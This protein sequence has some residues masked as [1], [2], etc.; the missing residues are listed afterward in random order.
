MALQGFFDVMPLPYADLVVS[1]VTAPP[2]AFSGETVTI[3]WSVE[4]QGIGLTSSSSWTDAI[5]LAD[6]PEGTGRFFVGG[7]QQLGFLAPGASYERE[8][9]VVLPEG[10]DGPA[11]FFVVVPGTDNVPSSSNPAGPAYEFVFNDEGNSAGSERMEVTLTPPPNLVVTAV[12]IPETGREGSAID[13]SWTVKNDGVGPANGSWTDRLVL[14]RAN[15]VGGDVTLGSYTFNGPLQAGTDYTRREQIILPAQVND[16]YDL[17]VITDHGETVF[18]HTNEGDNEST[19][20]TAQILVERLPRP[21]LQVF[22]IESGERYSA[23][24]TGALTYTVI[25]QGP[26]ATETPNWIDR[27]YLSLDEKVTSD[28]IRLAS[29]QN[30]AALGT[31]ERYRSGEVTFTIPKRFRGTVY[32]LVETDAGNAVGEWPNETNNVGVQEIFIDP[33]P[34]ADLV[35]DNVVTP[36]QA[37][38]GNSVTVTYTVTNR[39]AGA[40]DI[41]NWAEQIWLTTDKNRPHPNQGDVLLSTLTYSDGILDV[42]EGYDRTVTVTLPE[43]V[44]SGEYFITP[45]VDPYGTVLED[46]LAVNVNP[47]DPTELNSSNYRAGG[48]DVIGQPGKSIQIIGNPPDITSPDLA[49]KIDAV[50]PEAVA[51]VAGENAYEITYTLTN[52]GDR[53]AAGAFLTFTLTETPSRSFPGQET[54]NLGRFDQPAQLAPGESLTQTL[55]M[56]LAPGVDAGYLHGEVTLRGDSDASNDTDIALTSVTSPEPNLTIT[57]VLPPSD[58][59]S[60]EEITVGYTVENT[61]DA[62]IWDETQFWTDQV[63]ISPDATFIRQRATLLKSV[64]ISNADPLNPGDSYART[65]TGTLPQGVDGQ[66]YVHVFTNVSPRAA[67][68]AERRNSWPVTSGGGTS[69]LTGFNRQAF[70]DLAGN[71]LS[72]SFDITYAEPD[73]KVTNLVIPDDLAA[74]QDV[75]ISFTVTNV[76]TRATREDTWT[77]RV[78]LSLDSAL[79][80][81]DFLLRREEGVREVRAEAVRRGA[82]DIGESYTATVRVTLP[83]EVVGDFHILA[84][85]D[86]DLSDTS[87]YR[88]TVSDRLPGLLGSSLGDVLEFQG[89]GNNVTG[90]AVNIGPYVAPELAI[91]AMTVDERGTRGQTFDLS[92]TVTNS[93]GAVPFQQ[94]SWDDLVYFSRD[95]LLDLRAD[96]FLGR[97]RHSGGLGAGESYDVSE[98]FTIPTDMATE[99]YYVFVITDPNR[100]GGRGTVFELD[101]SNN[102]RASDVPLVIE[103]P[104]PTDLEVTSIT[105]PSDAAAGDPI[106]ISW[107]VTNQSD[108]VVAEGQWSDTAFLSQ[109]GTWDLSDPILGRATTSGP[110]APGE[111]RTLSIQTTMPAATPGGYRVIVRTDIFNQIHEDVGEANNTAASADTI[112]TRVDEL[113]IGTPTSINLVPGGEK[114]WRITVPPDETLRVRVLSSEPSASN[115]IFLRHDALPSPNAFDATYDGPLSSDL[116]AVVP[117]TEPGT[118][119]VSLRN[120]SGPGAGTDLTV[121]AELL[122]LVITDVKTDRGGAAAFVTTRISGAQFSEDATL[123]LVRPGIAEFAPVDW[124]VTGSDEIIA[125]FDLTGAPLGLYDVIV[126][127]PSGAQALAPYRF[128]VER[129]I[130]GDVTIG[131]GGS[132]TILA[133]DTET[134]SIAL[135]NQSNLD[136]PYTY[137]EVGVP[138]L[139]FNPYVYGLPFLDFFTNVRGTPDGATD[140]SVEGDIFW[141]GLESIVNTNGQLTT[142]GFAFDVPADGFTGFTFNLQTYP[143][144][145]ELHD[146]AFGAFRARMAGV[147]PELDGILEEGG[148][149]AIGE[150]YEAVVAKAAEVSPQLGAAMAAFPFQDLYEQNVARPGKCEIPFIPFRFHV[151]A[152]ATSMTRDE[153]I[154]HQTAEAL[155]LRDNILAADE[156]PAPLVAVVADPDLWVNLYLA[157]LE[158]AGVLRAEGEVPPIRQ[159]PQILSLMATLA[160][161]IL[162]GPAGQDIRSDGDILGFFEELRTLYGH[163]ETL[164]ADI[165]FYDPREA[166]DCGIVGEVPVPE[167]PVFE[168]YDLGLTHQTHFESVR[169]YSPWVPFGQRGE[170]LPVDFLN[171]A[172]NPVDGAGLQEL[173]F[174][175]YFANPANTTGALASIEGPQTLETEGWLPGQEAL[176]FT[177]NFQND[178]ESQTWANQIEVVTQLDDDL[179]P[180]SFRLGDIRI[181]DITIDVPDDRWFYQDEIDFSDTLGFVLRISAG[182]DLF[183]DPAAARWV[184]QAVDPLTGEKIQSSTRGLLPP[185][186]EGNRGAGFVSWTVEPKDTIET[187]NRITSLARVLFDTAPPEDTGELIQVVDAQA[188]ETR[189]DATPIEGTTSIQIDWDAK[190]DPGAS[191]VRHVTLYVA[192]NGGDFTIWQRRLPEAS[193][194]LVYDGV[195]GSTY[196]FLALATDIAGNREVPS[197]GSAVTS[198][199][200]AVNLG[201][202]A[203][204]DST[205]APNFGR[206]PDPIPEPSKNPLFTQALDAVPA[207]DPLSDLPEFES[208]L[209]PFTARAFATGFDASQTGI[210]PLAV[211]ELASGDVLVSGGA[212]RGEIHRFTDR[213]GVAASDTLLIALDEPIFNLAEAADGSLWATTGGGALLQLDPETGA[214]AESYGRGLTMGLAIDDEN[215]HIY[216]GSNTG[217]LRFDRET[218]RFT[219]WSRDENLRVSSLAFDRFGSL[220]AVTWPDRAQV[221]EFS[222]RQRGEI[223]LEFDAPIDSIAFGREGTLLE[224]LLF[225]SANAGAIGADGVATTGG[226]LTMV[227]VTTLQ[228]VDIAREGTRGDVVTTTRDGRI[229]V[230]QSSQVDVVAPAFSPAV[231]STSPEAD[232]VVPLPLNV[233][234]VTFDTDMFAGDPTS[235]ASVLNLANYVLTGDVAGAITPSAVI[236]DAESRTA[237]LRVDNLSADGYELRVLGSVASLQGLRMGEDYTTRFT[238]LDDLSTSVRA[239]FG[240]TRYDRATGTV[241]YDVTLTNISDRDLVLPVLLLLDPDRGYDGT[242][243]ANEGQSAE[244]VWIIDLSASLPA[245]GRLGAGESTTGQ[246]VGIATPNRQ[247][248]QFSAGVAAQAGPNAAPVIT[249]TPPTDA[250]VGETLSATVTATDADGDAVIYSLLE[251]PDGMTIDATTG[252]LEWT[253]LD[254]AAAQTPVTI[255]V[256]DARGAV[257]LQRFLIAVEDGNAAPSFFALPDLIEVFEGEEVGFDVIASDADGDTVVAWFDTLPE[258]AAY[259]AERR[260][261]SWATGYEQAGIYTLAVRAS[262][263]RAEVQQDV[264]IRVAEAPRPVTLRNPG[265]ITAVEGDRIRFDLVAEAEPGATLSFGVVNDTLPFGAQLNAATGEFDWTPDFTQ[266]DTYRVAFAVSDGVGVAVQIVEI[267]VT[268]G[269]GAPVFDNFD[270]LQVYEGQTFSIR[271]FAEDPDNPFYEPGFRDFDGNVTTVDDVIRTVDVEVLNPLPEGATFDPDTWELQWTPGAAQAGN[272]TFRFRATDDGDLT[273]TPLSSETEFTLTVLDLNQAPVL[274]EPSNITL[275]AGERRVIPVSAVDPDGD[276]VELTL[277][278]ESPG[279]PLPDYI[280]FTDNGDG[281]GQIVIDSTLTDRGDTA[282]TLVAYDDGGAARGDES[283]RR[284]ALHTFIISVESANAP[285]VFDPQNDVVAVAGEELNLTLSVSDLDQDAL[286]FALAGLPTG[287]TLTADP[288]IYGQAHLS[289]TPTAAQIGNFTAQVTASDDG[290][291]GTVSAASTTLA[292]GIT[293]RA[294]NVAPV[295]DPIGTIAG[296]EGETLRATFGASDADGDALTFRA[297]NLPFGARFDRG[298]GTLVWD[299]NNL[300]AGTFTFDLTV[301]DGSAESSETVTITIDDANRAPVFVPVTTQ[302]GRERAEMRFTVVASD[303]DGDPVRLSVLSG[304]PERAAFSEERGEFVWIPTFEDAGRYTLL[305]G[306]QDINGA[307]TTYAVEIDI[308]DINRAPELSASDRAFIVGEE[309]SFTLEATDLDGQDLTFEALD[310]PDGATLDDASGTV[311]WTPGPGQVGDFFVTFLARDGRGGVDRQTIVMRASL[312]PVEP[313]V[314][315]E[316]VPSFPAILGQ[317]VAVRVVADSIADIT[318][319]RL[320]AGDDE[321]TLDDRGRAIL[322]APDPGKLELRAEATDADGIT[323]TATQALKVRDAAD[324]TAP[325]LT[326]DADLSVFPLSGVTPL[327]GGIDDVN[328]DTWQLELLDRGGNR[329][330]TLASGE[331]AQAAGI[332]LADL[333]TRALQNGFYTLRLTARDIGGRV[334]T[335]VRSVEVNGSE[336]TGLLERVE[337]DL[338][339]DM[340]G[341]EIALTRRYNPLAGADRDFGT[342]SAGFDLELALDTRATGQETVGVFAALSEGARL[343]LTAPDGARLGFTLV[344]ERIEIGS[345]SFFRANWVAD[346]PTAG[347]TLETADSPLRK[348]GNR[349]FTAA[350]VPY[351]PLDPAAAGFQPFVLRNAAMGLAYVAD[352]DGQVREIQKGSGRF[353]V[354]ASGI[355]AATGEVL[356]FLRDANGRIARAT[357]PDGVSVVYTY[358]SE[359]R[360]ARVRDLTDGSSTAYGYNDRALALAASDAGEARVFLRDGNGEVTTA[361]LAATLGGVAEISSNPQTGDASGGDA[362]YALTIRESD[363]DRGTGDGRGPILRVALTGG[364]PQR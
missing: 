265:S 50:T 171:Q 45:W 297:D 120:F 82:L 248:V 260:R 149:E 34:F 250:R 327:V 109:D 202:T 292:L 217:V 227:D 41:G 43:S 140:G 325:V 15:G 194:T 52:L 40:T 168:D 301:S 19:N 336:K 33:I 295:L 235:A 271:A 103:L 296:T 122:P 130:E 113:L 94:G 173:N 244:G 68:E 214:V 208:V 326:L 319:V 282:V 251:A 213:G 222:D 197:D 234:S 283:T 362:F 22:E 145:R 361:P 299:V 5:Y 317:E 332:T 215:G 304:L 9:Q 3:S 163:D 87:R 228:R 189:I 116:V 36:P 13:V 80:T 8:A 340:G 199:G 273:G 162:F 290:A 211:L 338:R 66:Y 359:G 289:W 111:S 155:A 259:D 89:E 241:S 358:D 321:I 313:S 11:Y 347:W 102:A 188:P 306:A 181:G 10:W 59:F 2:T 192:E 207:A 242:P 354:G 288:A 240:G 104:P 81:G 331:D 270:G 132:R 243:D 7:A 160:S 233:I 90:Q 65:V 67:S 206:A 245:D 187:G 176:P 12:T 62:A 236:Y 49:L 14:R 219:Q 167:L 18:E 169:I 174:E 57:Q 191:G 110:L 204:V 44:A 55:T 346:D 76:G 151:F 357:T 165:E 330:M 39:G 141:A 106:T 252:I 230:S 47:D 70:E 101:D 86:T 31:G 108:S 77:D 342:F 266:A 302:L 142:S 352:T 60:G 286:T 78:Y 153:F 138:E 305:L 329:L 112:D 95:P 185:N 64:T 126:T 92:Y 221:I 129:G 170:A 178:A 356:S 73:L 345:R 238:G 177:V 276:P 337:T 210:A 303:P 152:A 46:A 16:R 300:Q 69:E 318:S 246:T 316:L 75:D 139:H 96:R 38:E 1:D 83:F 229:L 307:T 144:L 232:G 161:G 135:E 309:R 125:T 98:S 42:D 123:R 343:Y 99:A 183:Q 281:T 203:T 344:P 4:N 223:R 247:R 93:G 200:Q 25:N 363:I 128:L 158:E 148:E 253:P 263:G 147:L 58:P 107:T 85:A 231:Q 164:M 333:D 339:A 341:I 364:H 278:N 272:Y 35:L 134:Y 314:R 156:A 91:S 291:G 284:G 137:F 225:V 293:V 285:P 6:N 30:E 360:L 280:T 32:L 54:W 56:R 37:F 159:N 117:S 84:A 180:R 195:E 71:E 311:T 335:L 218:G 48:G 216:V 255:Q 146:E 61:G 198:D 349:F 133:G 322:T 26:V 310:L 212:N 298:T 150:W 29:L 79:D 20:I 353:F 124:E 88:S 269:N 308:A 131:I 258:G 23:G 24:A 205:T 249:S 254:G 74:G 154:A 196:E 190:D 53:E 51:G 136:A 100:G 121:L 172:A 277:T 166:I 118:Y 97:I 351:T 312:E 334:S 224:D 274:V 348:S 63:W 28:D 184:L 275:Q 119:Y 264:T 105:L 114:L 186:S 179:D 350:G 323:G 262:D 226:A 267:E 72:A 21:D 257:T 315:I 17:I 261:F 320:F 256:F 294:T 27:V 143:G 287:A 324:R 193:G 115:E 157:G 127:N 237:L 182:V 328:L 355:T 239:T 201:G 279:L 175:E 268:N 209:S 220:W